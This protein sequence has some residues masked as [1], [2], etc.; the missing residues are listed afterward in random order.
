MVAGDVLQTQRGVSFLTTVL[1]GLW[2]TMFQRLLNMKLFKGIRHMEKDL[3]EQLRML[4]SL[5]CSYS[6]IC[7]ARYYVLLR[8]K[9]EINGPGPNPNQ[10]HRFHRAKVL[11]GIVLSLWSLS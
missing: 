7:C 6:R 11:V 10:A 1:P 5:G 2:K 8:K 4:S 9:Y 3:L